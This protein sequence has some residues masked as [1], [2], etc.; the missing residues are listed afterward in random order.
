MRLEIRRATA[1]DAPAIWS[2]LEPVF[3]AG[4]TYTVPSDISREAALSY[5]AAPER[6]VF[7]AV[8]GDDI[9]GTYYITPNQQ[10]GGAHVCNCG[11]VTAQQAQG[12]GVARAML[13][14][15]LELAPQLGFRAM[16][17]NFVVESNSRAIDTWQKAGFST[18]GRLPGAFRHPSLGYV[19]ALIMWRD[20]Q[21]AE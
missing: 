14:H 1:A 5:W 6:Q 4:D 18:I 19:D 10:G 11:Y 8:D 20:L 15:S 3:R 13:A 12:R 16:Q 17:Y 2:V 7:V 21:P 9:L